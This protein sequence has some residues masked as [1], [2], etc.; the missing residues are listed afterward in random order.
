MNTPSPEELDQVALE[1]LVRV[2]I[3]AFLKKCG[4]ADPVNLHKT[5]LNQV[6]KPL[7][8]LVLKRSR[9][10][11]IKAARILGLNRNT[12]RKKIEAY[13]LNSGSTRKDT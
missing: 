12:L 5:I 9:G 8:E 13:H 4:A 11:Q 1:E 10:N 6:E 3:E 7:L 2:K